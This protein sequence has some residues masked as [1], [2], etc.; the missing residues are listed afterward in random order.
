MNTLQNQAEKE[1]LATADN[2]AAA[3]TNFSGYG[4]DV[5]ITARETLKSVVHEWIERVV[6]DAEENPA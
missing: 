6:R 4:Y 1:I 2:L 5:F 3:A